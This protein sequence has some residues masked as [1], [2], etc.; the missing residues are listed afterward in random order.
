MKKVRILGVNIDSITK[1]KTFE[2][3]K[4]FFNSSK[5]HYIVT[6][7]P[8]FLIAAKRDEEFYQILNRADLSLADGFGVVLMSHLI[9]PRIKRH[10]RG[11][12]LT[13]KLL[14][15]AEEQGLKVCILN[16]N[17]SLSKKDDIEI[18]L[19]NKY[20]NLKFLV[21]DIER[22]GKDAK[23]K[24]INEFVPKLLFVTLGARYQEK[25]IYTHLEKIPSVRVAMGVGGTF[26]FLTE[27]IERAPV[28]MRKIEL[29]W[30]WR[31]IQQ[32]KRIKR[33]FKAVVV[34]PLVFLKEKLINPHFY[35]RNVA[36]L[37]YKKEKGKIKIFLAEREDEKGHFQLPQ[38][39]TEGEDIRDAGKRELSEEIGTKRFTFKGEF[40]NVHKYKFS[41]R[42]GEEIRSHKK[43]GVYKH[44]N[45]KGQKQS[46]YVAEFIGK[47]SDIKLFPYDFRSWKWVSIEK[48]LDIVHPIRREGVKKFLKKFESIKK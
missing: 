40:E 38:G 23:I 41:K 44:S 8:E 4:G 17:T 25:F 31:L 27:K 16:W 19:E 35:R 21:Q 26:D 42:S 33:I 37:M 11:S 32:P 15:E 46:L 28:W 45:Y 34:F 29:E 6:V 9:P 13:F 30:L 10:I 48:V 1:N 36:C 12:D 18:V 7:N 14:K 24:E 20:P 22:G 2:V 3:I 47:D 5:Q 43:G 39:G